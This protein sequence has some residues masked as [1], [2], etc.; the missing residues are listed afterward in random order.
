MAVAPLSD[1]QRGDPPAWRNLALRLPVGAEVRTVCR[2]YHGFLCGLP[3]D[4]WF[5]EGPQQLSPCGVFPD[6]FV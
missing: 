6:A 2:G 5:G 3:R 4:S 1:L